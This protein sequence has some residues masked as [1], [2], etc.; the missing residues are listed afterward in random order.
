MEFENSCVCVF[1]QTPAHLAIVNFI[2]PVQRR[3]QMEPHVD[4]LMQP[5]NMT[6][7]HTD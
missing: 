3:N 1:K 5:A 7:H 6:L 2:M 4:F